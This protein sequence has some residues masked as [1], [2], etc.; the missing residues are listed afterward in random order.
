MGSPLYFLYVIPVKGF[1]VYPSM[2]AL[3]T[4]FV[5]YLADISHQYFSPFDR[6]EGGSHRLR[7]NLVHKHDDTCCQEFTQE[8]VPAYIHRVRVCSST[9][10][11]GT[12]LGPSGDNQGPR[13]VMSLHWT[14]HMIYCTYNTGLKV[15]YP[16]NCSDM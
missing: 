4:D 7:E 14:W 9:H 16:V 11:E 6:V 13:N 2:D 10:K 1:M 3:G 15:R 8:R 5:I 12:V